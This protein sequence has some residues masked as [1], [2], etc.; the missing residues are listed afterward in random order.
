MEDITKSLETL[1]ERAAEYGKTSFELA[2]LNTLDKT[3]DIVSSMIPHAVVLLILAFS[4]LFFSMGLAFWLGEKLGNTCY[5]F[6]VLAAF[7][8]LTGIILRV[9]FHVPL[10]RL[11][12]NCFIKK[13]LK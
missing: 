12:A 9:F 4:M 3:S 11:A 8:L 5:G 2:K 13:V 10:K 1:L 6:F 7:Y